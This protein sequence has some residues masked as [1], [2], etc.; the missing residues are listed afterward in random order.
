MKTR[1]N[2]KYTRELLEPLVKESFS[3]YQVLKKLNLS[4]SG[5]NNSY[6][7]KNIKKYNIDISHFTGSGWRK[8]KSF[9]V[10]RIKP[11]EVLIFDRLNGRREKAYVL[12]RSL[13][14]SGVVH[15]CAICDLPPE[16]LGKP[17][18]LQIDHIDGNPLNNVKD[19]LR[20]LCGNCHI[21]TPT[22]GF[23]KR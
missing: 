20:F 1:Y 22:F 12:R 5:G 7:R 4:I 11:E 13:I 18:Q 8:G 17:L 15:K 19:N 2:K 3:F 6:I 21:Q 9:D 14:E 10:E 23:K 16:W